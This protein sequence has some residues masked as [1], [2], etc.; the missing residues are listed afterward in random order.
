MKFIFGE[1]YEND[2]VYIEAKNLQHAIKIFKVSELFPEKCV[3]KVYYKKDN[4][5]CYDQEY[6]SDL[7]R[8]ITKFKINNPKIFIHEQDEKEEWKKIGQIGLQ[9]C[10][11][12]NFKDIIP[13]VNLLEAPEAFKTPDEEPE[14]LPIVVNAEAIANVSSKRELREKH[15]QIALK[16]AELE[17]MVSEMNQ[18]MA[19]LK[20]E[21]KQKQKVVYIIETYL[22]IHEKVIQITEGDPAPEGSKL[23]L[24]QQKLFMDE[25]VGIWDDKDGQGIDFQNIEQFDDWI[26]KHYKNFA[27]EPLSIVVWQVRRK[28]KNYDTDI[29]THVQFDHWNKTTYFLIR[30]GDRLYRIWSN[31]S[32]DDRLFPTKDEYI[33]I[34]REE[35]K[36]GNDHAKEKLQEKHEGYLY[37][38][39]AIQGIIERTDILGTHLRQ[40]GINLLSPRSDIDEHI[41]FI[42]D[43]ETDFWI[44]NG[45]PRWKDFIKS[46]RT[47]I[48]LGSRICLSTEKFYF[49]LS[50]KDDNDRWRCSPYRPSCVPPRDHWYLVEA[51][52][53]ESDKVY[54]PHGT[55]LLI[56]YKPGD[57]VGWDPYSGKEI[58]RKRRIPWFLYTDEV[59]N[60]DGITLEEA[61]YYM[62]SRLD[63]ENYLR[64]LP[65][66]HWIRRIKLKEKELE[67]EFTKMIASQLKWELDDTSHHKIQK[68][69]NWWK[70][71]NKWKRALT[72]KE[73]T[74]TRMILKKLKG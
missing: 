20:N 7:R 66:L 27:Y 59:I 23:A 56:R 48:K 24:Y 60:F 31:V 26:S 16:K 57:C 12:V 47:T 37:G 13:Q 43:A 34:V 70:L 21:L 9:E 19:V 18:A 5:G 36:W 28:E 74:A 6:Q 15:D 22:G 71:K 73:S 51:H 65:T 14:T 32:V 69:I 10:I 39:I 35:Y 54:F 52:E 30:N 38:L 4:E 1:P 11:N 42:R 68:A 41:K 44:G 8:Y 2:S 55:T 63:R 64:L 45:K 50:S 53:E 3:D 17:N 33:K 49:S 58:I 46:N 61:D 25:E 29:W 67:D 72:T 40:Q 62:K